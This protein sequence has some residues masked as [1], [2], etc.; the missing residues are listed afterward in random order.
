MDFLT[1]DIRYVKGVGEQRAKALKKLGIENYRSLLHH[2]PRDY[3]DH[4]QTVSVAEAYDYVDRYVSMVAVIASAVSH[5]KIRQNLS[6]S[7]VTVVDESGKMQLTFFNNPYLKNMFH[8]GETY[9][10]YGKVEQFGAMLTMTSPYFEPIREGHSPALRPIYPLCAGV[11]QKMLSSAIGYVLEQLPEDYEPLPDYIAVPLKLMPYAAALRNI[12]M[13]TDD[14]CLSAAKKRLEFEE[15]FYYLLGLGL[16]RQKGQQKSIFSIQKTDNLF[17]KQSPFTPTNAQK[18]VISEIRTD[19]QSGSRMNRL[20]Q[21]DVGSGK[22]FVAGDAAWQMLK[23][24]RQVA[25]M[26]PTAILATQHYQYFAPIFETLGKKCAL[27]ISAMTAK[28][29]REVYAGLADGS[30]DFVVGT[31]ALI[32]KDVAFQSLALV[33]TDE[34]HRFGV[35]QRSEI[36]GK[37]E[38][39]HVLAM[40]ATP[41]PRTMALILYGDLDIS[42][43]DELPAGRQKISTYL[44]DS[45]YEQRLYNFIGKQLAL[46]GQ[47]YFVCPLVEDSEMMDLTSVQK[48]TDTLKK[49]FPETAMLHGKMKPAE[50][51][52]VM[53]DFV[54]GKVKILVSTTVIE[55]GINVPDATLMIVRDA[56]RFGLSQLHQLRGRV[57]RGNKKSYCVLLSDSRSESA[58]ERMQF[59]TTTTD[60]FVIAQKDL[61]L[62]G[63]GDLIGMRQ[64][65]E[66]QM[67]MLSRGCD[68]RQLELAQ[69]AARHVLSRDPDLSSPAH[70][71]LKRLMMDKF[72][73]N[74]DIFN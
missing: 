30:I 45:D 51:E 35:G 47:V 72:K 38:L 6:V 15:L 37:G 69:R 36:S 67:E 9:L 50:K 1:T 3:I 12:H 39:P 10:F 14:T 64:S 28:A 43:I 58:R 62:R 48:Q 63:P 17:V 2:F 18:R 33:V 26:V 56:E 65:G 25:V 31:H 57:G 19:F 73:E 11:T 54:S 66:S 71:K 34:Q 46:G 20:L 5:H 22:T 68:M 59:F 55:V 27:L 7:K 13:P 16:L 29:K 8:I 74:G 23:E 40:S 53:A 42:V 49:Q 21:G 41:I 61:S 24:G 32:Q 44:V 52:A 4:R 60:G 70:R